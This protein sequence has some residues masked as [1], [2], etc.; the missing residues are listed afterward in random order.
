MMYD[1]GCSRKLRRIV[2]PSYDDDH[3]LSFW[4]ARTISD[5][6]NMKWKHSE[7]YNNNE[8]VFNEFFI[9]W[10]LPVMVV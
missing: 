1:V 4:T 2:F 5:K 3:K 8:M 9:N 10:S 6:I 7:G